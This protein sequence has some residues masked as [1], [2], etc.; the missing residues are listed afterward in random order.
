MWLDRVGWMCW[1]LFHLLRYGCLGTNMLVVCGFEEAR[2]CLIGLLRLIWVC[3]GEPERECVC[4]MKHG[5]VFFGLG[6]L[7]L[8]FA[9]LSASSFAFIPKRIVIFWM[10]IGRCC[11]MSFLGYDFYE[12]SARVVLLSGGVLYM[13]SY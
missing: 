8:S 6:C 5:C 13:V 1:L 3:F 10:V 4:Y 7:G 2:R 9:S 11:F 12:V